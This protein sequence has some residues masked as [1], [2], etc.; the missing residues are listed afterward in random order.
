MT[1]RVRAHLGI[2]IPD[3]MGAPVR[4]AAQGT[5]VFSG[6]SRGYGNLI[7]IDHGSGGETR[8]GHLSTITVSRGDIVTQGMVIGFIGSTGHS[9]GPHLHFEVRQDGAAQNPL[10]RFGGAF[11]GGV[12]LPQPKVQA[13]V[14]PH[15]TGF[16]HKDNLLPQPRLR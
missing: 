12:V 5:I 3:V 9:T 7:Q 15:Q 13:A 11:G 2:D 10:I 1:R 4:A 14:Q 8:Y 6:W 16:E